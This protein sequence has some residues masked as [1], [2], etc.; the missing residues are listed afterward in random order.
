M[1][2]V[3]RER[4]DAIYTIGDRKRV[5]PTLACPNCGA[6]AK[7]VDMVDYFLEAG[8]VSEYGWRC[9]VCC[10]YVNVRTNTL[11]PPKTE[12]L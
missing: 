6:D 2:K 10:L 11:A 8:T 12:H 3:T 9:L 5:K 1:S 4:D 7:A